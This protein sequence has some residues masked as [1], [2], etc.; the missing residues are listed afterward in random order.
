MSEN[1][2]SGAVGGLIA[3]FAAEPAR[4][5]AT[6]GSETTLAEGLRAEV[7]SRQH[8]IVIDEPTALGGTDTGP[9]P[10]EAVLSGLVSCQAISYK[11]WAAK[12]GIALEGVTVEAEGSIDLLGFFGIDDHV[13]PGYDGVQLKVSL[14]GPESPERYHELADA[15]D[16][17]CPVLDNLRNPVPVSRTLVEAAI[18]H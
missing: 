4:A 8:T 12:L 10:V 1:A 14:S 15:V 13:R 5:R 2:E 16:A 18:T 9:N 11:V 6:F 17:H 3:L 7:N